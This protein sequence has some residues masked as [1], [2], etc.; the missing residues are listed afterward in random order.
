MEEIKKEIEINKEIEKKKEKIKSWLKNKNFAFLSAILIFA[1]FVRI[2]F[3]QIAKNQT[4]WWDSLAYGNIAKNLIFHMWDESVY[5]LG[6]LNIRPPLFPF[7]LSFLCFLDT[8]F[9]FS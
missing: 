8:Y 5:I 2:Y 3:F 1:F 4:H 6:E 9:L 7:F